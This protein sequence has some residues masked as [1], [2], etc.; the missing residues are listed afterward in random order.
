MPAAPSITEL[1][2]APAGA[3][4]RATSPGQG[5]GWSP[6]EKWAGE[7]EKWASPAARCGCPKRDRA[8]QRV[9]RTAVTGSRKGQR[10]GMRGRFPFPGRHEKAVLK[11]KQPH[12]SRAA[13]QRVVLVAAGG[14]LPRMG[15]LPPR[16]PPGRQG[17][18]LGWDVWQW[19]PVGSRILPRPRGVPTSPRCHLRP[20]PQPDRGGRAGDVR[21]LHFQQHIHFHIHSVFISQMYGSVTMEKKENSE[22]V[23]KRYSN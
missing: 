15:I 19:G 10:L 21:G 23:L 1:C 9:I 16:S 22:F 2:Q 4:A 14:Q 20:H 5:Q 18:T 11:K 8:S 13:I 3:G 17:G 6:K 7:K 12:L